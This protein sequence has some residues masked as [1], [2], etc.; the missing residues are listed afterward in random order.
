MDPQGFLVLSF[1][2]SHG[3]WS[4]LSGDHRCVRNR[5]AL[6]LECL[7]FYSSSLNYGPLA[8]PDSMRLL[9]KAEL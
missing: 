2:V 9:I 1:E 6:L 3:V 4:E 5:Y 8:L 7:A